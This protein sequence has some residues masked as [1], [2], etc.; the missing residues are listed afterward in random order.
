MD[1]KEELQDVAVGDLLRIEDDFHGFGVGSVIAV[2]RVGDVTSGVSDASRENA[3]PMPDQFLCSP[4]A[5]SGEDGG[6]GRCSH[7]CAPSSE[8]SSMLSNC[9]R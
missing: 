3:R 5:A 4:E 8:L 9:A 6:L 1:L 2:G 7:F